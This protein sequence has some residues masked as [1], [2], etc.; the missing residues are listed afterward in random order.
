MNNPV[1]KISFSKSLLAGLLTGIIIAL[2]NVI[3]MIIYR[4]STGFATAKIIM[5]FSIFLGFPILLALGGTVYYLF[6]KR[7]PKGTGWFIFFCIVLMVASIL[8]TILDTRKDGG[9]LLSG[10]R[11]L[12]LSLEVIAFLLGAN[13]IPY[14]A[15]HPNIYQ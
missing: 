15:T 3:Y 4:E 1:N 8:V 14:L 9:S 11:G 12:C 10:I 2:I 7:L 6:K 5:P 13:L